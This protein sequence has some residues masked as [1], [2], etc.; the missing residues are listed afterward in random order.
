MIFEIGDFIKKL[1]LMTKSA[2][3]VCLSLILKQIKLFSMPFG[4][5]VTFGSLAPLIILSSKYGV[6]TG[7]FASFVCLA[8]HFVMSFK[9]PPAKSF[10]AIALIIFFDYVLQYLLV[11]L[12]GFFGRVFSFGRLNKMYTGAAVSFILKIFSSAV[13]GA[14]F[15]G[16]YAPGFL[17]IPIY[18]LAY[19]CAYLIPEFLITVI[20][21]K[22]TEKFV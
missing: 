2:L 16:E 1:H 11:G 21:I 10:F 14:V 9:V 15:W 13:S 5:S 8:V 7:V 6:K 12:S 22:K 18:S 20:V 4:G 3:M 19:S 17:S